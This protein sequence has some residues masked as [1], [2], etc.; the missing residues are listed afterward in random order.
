MTAHRV[1][2]GS[3]RKRVLMNA[4]IIDSEGTQRVRVVD[5]NSLGARIAGNRLIPVGEDLIF[6]RGTLFV[7]ARVAWSNR[8]GTGLQF[9]REIP[10]AQIAST[11]HTV[12]EA[13][14]VAAE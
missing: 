4:T 7:A 10:L 3:E 12:F 1:P 11:F 5:L 8:A 9:Y 2:R 6:S 13:Q 14:A